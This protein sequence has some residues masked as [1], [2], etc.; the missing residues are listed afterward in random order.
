[1]TGQPLTLRLSTTTTAPGDELDIELEPHDVDVLRDGRA[2]VVELVCRHDCRKVDMAPSR[3]SYARREIALDNGE[4]ATRS[5]RLEVPADAPIS[6]SGKLIRNQWRLEVS[7]DVARSRDR[8]LTST[9]VI[10][11][12]RSGNER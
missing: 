2:V 4:L 7:L 12:P 11:V 3:L 10:V 8:E 1:M 9:D 5:V 6:F